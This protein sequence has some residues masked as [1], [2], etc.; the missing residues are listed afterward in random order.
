MYFTPYEADFEC[1]KGHKFVAPVQALQDSAEVICP[2]CYAEWVAEN[3]PSAK[4][5]SG[6]RE[7]KK[8]IHNNSEPANE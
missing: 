8:S 7:V 2:T 5:V 1:P 3:V 6:F 4:Q